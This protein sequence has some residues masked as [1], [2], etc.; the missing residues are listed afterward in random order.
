MN[1]AYCLLKNNCSY[2]SK[3]K[4][5]SWSCI[6]FNKNNIHPL[7]LQK[8][9]G[10]NL[11]L[12]KRGAT[13]LIHD[14]LM[15]VWNICAA[16]ELLKVRRARAIHNA[17]TLLALLAPSGCASMLVKWERERERISVACE[18]SDQSGGL[19]A[20]VQSAP[21]L[22]LALLV[23]R[24]IYFWNDV[25]AQEARGA[26][27]VDSIILSTLGVTRALPRCALCHRRRR[28]WRHFCQQL[29]QNANPSRRKVT[30]PSG[31]RRKHT[32]QSWSRFLL[33]D[34]H[35][36]C[37]LISLSHLNI[38]HARRV[39]NGPP[40]STNSCITRSWVHWAQKQLTNNGAICGS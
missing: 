39:T 13:P 17:V 19:V 31:E 15:T 20:R 34:S 35:K 32:A 6:T 14:C 37:W 28:R 5:S 9:L 29:I 21:S 24:G 8:Q 27:L 11:K 36:T 23:G 7:K 38:H 12:I 33:P 26:R 40:G 4:N 30:C 18:T 16:V 2:Y 3:I 22:Y 10:M 25:N 1:Q